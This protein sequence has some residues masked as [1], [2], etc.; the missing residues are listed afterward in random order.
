MQI[1]LCGDRADVVDDH[2]LDQD[3]AVQYIVIGK[4]LF[5]E[6]DHAAQIVFGVK[7]D[8]RWPNF[9]LNALREK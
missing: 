4:L 6:A 8:E 2:V 1:V 9:L 7:D 3:Q 5:F